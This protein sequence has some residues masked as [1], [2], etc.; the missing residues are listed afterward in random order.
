MPMTFRKS[1]QYFG[2]KILNANCLDFMAPES[3][4][5]FST[6]LVD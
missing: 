1:L 6:V 4:L 3:T 2:Q 5:N